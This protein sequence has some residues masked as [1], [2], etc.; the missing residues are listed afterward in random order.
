MRDMVQEF[1]EDRK[2]NTKLQEKLMA[3]KKEKQELLENMHEIET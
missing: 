3:M 2:D 1:V